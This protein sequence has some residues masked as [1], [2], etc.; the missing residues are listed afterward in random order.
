MRG[1]VRAAALTTTAAV[2]VL[3]VW[4]GSA[5]AAVVTIGSPIAG[6][7]SEVTFSAD[8][9]VVNDRLGAPGAVLA[10]PVTG[11]VIRWRVGG[12]EGGPLQLR[13][14]TPNPGGTYAATGTSDPATPTNTQLQVFAAAVPIKAGQ[15]IGLN[16]KKDNKIGAIGNPAS[17]F[18]KWEPPLAE[19]QAL[20][21][22]VI[23]PLGA[24]L[25]FN[26]DV[27][28]AP[29]VSLIAP[30]S[31]SIRGR[32]TV[33]IAGTDFV[34]VKAVEFGGVPATSFTVS[35]EGLIS[36]V[37][38]AATKPGPVDVTVTTVAGK[39]ATV[40]SDRFAYTACVVPKL[41]RKSVKADRK[42]LKKAGCKL[43]KVTR[44]RGA[45]KGAK[46]I[47]Q[48]RKPGT[49]LPPGTKVNVK[50]G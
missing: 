33:S 36:A 43:G 23:S 4:A 41:K 27:L 13:V 16:G 10:S 39:T 40:A 18:A 7:V 20:A 25:A 5:G 50:V 9:T 1:L 32:T 11:A 28:P 42:A 44:K 48:T 12:A 19:G 37:A 35:N 26:A 47:K 29:T 6:P 49:V 2:A 17:G 31:G 45:G 22:T 46:V 24:E 8:M 3:G 30:A 34:E 15:L 14:L 38:P 21:P